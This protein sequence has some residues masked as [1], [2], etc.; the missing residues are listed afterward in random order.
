[1]INELPGAKGIRIGHRGPTVVSCFLG[2]PTSAALR[3]MAEAQATV[4]KQY[5]R[6]TVL[7]IIPAIDVALLKQQQGEAAQLQ[8]PDEERNASMKE[9][10]S[11]GEKLESTTLASA[12]VILPKGVLAVMI[13]SFIGAMSLVGRSR[14]PLQ[15][16]KEL[17][18]AITW[19]EA[20]PNAGITRGLL[21]DVE[22]WLELASPRA[23]VAP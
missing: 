4:S 9:S 14:A 16:F 10:A 23:K 1:M 5:G 20:Q 21:G 11:T 17:A 19:L 13:R 8:L 15:T 22:A 2:W 6:V 3:A 7:S 18:P 12:L